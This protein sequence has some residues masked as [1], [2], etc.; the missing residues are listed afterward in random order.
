M[1]KP[2]NIGQTTDLLKFHCISIF[3]AFSTVPGRSKGLF[4]YFFIYYTY[5]K[6]APNSTMYSSTESVEHGCYSNCLA[7]I[8]PLNNMSISAHLAG[9]PHFWC[10]TAHSIYRPPE[11]ESRAGAKLLPRHQIQPNTYFCT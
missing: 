2:D 7:I 4:K 9:S 1:S 5:G 11:P 6:N 3:K 8:M 10:Y